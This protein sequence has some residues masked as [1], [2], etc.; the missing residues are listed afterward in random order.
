[1][2]CSTDL[3]LQEEEIVAL[4][5]IYGPDDFSVETQ[6]TTSSPSRTLS[7]TLHLSPGSLSFKC[8]IPSDY[9][10]VSA[11]VYELIPR[12]RWQVSDETRAEIDAGLQDLF[13]PGEVVVF[14]WVAFAQ[15]VLERT[16]GV[17]EEAR[18]LEEAEKETQQSCSGPAAAPETESAKSPPAAAEEEEDQTILAVPPDCPPIYTTTTPIVDRKSIFIAHCA[19]VSNVD[20][21]KKVMNVLLSNKYV[22]VVDNLQAR[23]THNI[24]AYRIV[25]ENGVVRQDC[26]DDGETA[27]GGRLLHMLQ[28]AD[29]RGAL[30][31]VT[32]FYG[33]IHL[34]PQRFKHINNIARQALETQGFIRDTSVGDGKGKNKGKHSGGK[35]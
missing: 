11:P 31:V 15:E 22:D 30:I 6:D 27:A 33:G 14:S 20:D 18:D 5:A 17:A 24:S 9:P 3:D 13:V 35:R 28:L 25:E 12:G 29:V 19:P 21:V 7:V 34:G 2:S 32:R 1:M 26:D 16:Y 4:S 8:H 10:S 23:A